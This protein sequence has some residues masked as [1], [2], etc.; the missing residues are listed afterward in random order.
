MQSS[1]YFFYLEYED[2]IEDFILYD[3]EEFII[4]NI[5]FSFSD[6]HVKVIASCEDNPDDYEDYLRSYSEDKAIPISKQKFLE[7]KEI[8]SSDESLMNSKEFLHKY[9]LEE[10]II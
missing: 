1:K 10:W 3:L 4:Y 2:K 9:S 8:N 5:Y 7:L 6:S